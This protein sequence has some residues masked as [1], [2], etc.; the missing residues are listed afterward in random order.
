MAPAKIARK[1]LPFLILMAAVVGF[2]VLRATGPAAP[3]PETSERIWQIRGLAVEPGTH[4]PSVELFG[5]TASPSTAALRAAIEGEVAQVPVREGEVV[6]PG[7]LLIRIDPA[8]IRLTLAQ[9][10]AELREAQSLVESEVLRAQADRRILGRE[11]QLLQIAQ[12]GVDRAQ[13]LRAGNLGSEAAL[14]EAQRSL[15]QA[16]VAVDTR[17]Q[18]VNDAPGRLLQAQARLERLQAALERAQLDLRR[19]EIR[20]PAQARVVEVQV[21]PGERVRIGDPLLRLQALDDLE[22]RASLPEVLLPRI[23]PLLRDGV[24]LLAHATVGGQAVTAE[25]VRLAGAAASGEAGM[26]AL[27][28][29]LE[30]GADL[31]L[32][33]F[34]NLRLHLPE[35]SD[36]VVV[37]FETL[38]GRD[39]IYRVIDGRM[40]GLRVERLGEVVDPQGQTRAL[41]RHSEL[42]AGDVLV[43]TRLP[44][45]VDGLRVGV[46]MDA[47]DVAIR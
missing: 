13:E 46:T 22:I 3:P 37:P 2:M 44:N 17:E 31:P 1:I 12:R 19:S 6:A 15:E 39:R 18:A 11:R 20:A 9:R 45:A 42:A 43:V 7:T 24:P 30:G 8:E 25:L 36:A 29:V 33:R 47:A 16:R 4:R 32:N 41:V 40:Q 26:S 34:V 14:D 10:E 35:E 5:R 23:P 21:S 27:F 38:Y 28:R